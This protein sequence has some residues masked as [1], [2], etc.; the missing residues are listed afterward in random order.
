MKAGEEVRNRIGVVL[1]AEHGFTSERLLEFALKPKRIPI[2][3]R[4]TSAEREA[5]AAAQ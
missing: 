5:A 2:R 4:K 3:R 1:R